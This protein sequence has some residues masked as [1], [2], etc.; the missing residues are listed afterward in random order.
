[1][2]ELLVSGRVTGYRGPL[3]DGGCRVFFFGAEPGAWPSLVGHE[4]SRLW[5]WHWG[6]GNMGTWHD[7]WK[8]HHV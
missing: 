1:M 8:T 6:V 7:S 3:R 4:L 5:R 2:G